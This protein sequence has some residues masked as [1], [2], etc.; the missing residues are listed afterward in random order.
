MDLIFLESIP[1]SIQDRTYSHREDQVGRRVRLCKCVPLNSRKK[2]WR[3]F[4][5]PLLVAP[6]S[7]T[8]GTGVSRV[9]DV[10]QVLS[11]YISFVVL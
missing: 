11:L 3:S 7:I 10:R 5:M 6:F 9:V 1:S 4:R 2:S 8:V